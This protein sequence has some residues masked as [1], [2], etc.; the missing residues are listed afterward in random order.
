MPFN[1]SLIPWLFVGVVWIGLP[2]AALL[3]IRRFLRSYERRTAGPSELAE[4]RAKVEE[5]QGQVAD[6]TIEHARLR[7][8]ER[9]TNAL[10]RDTS[11]NLERD[12][13]G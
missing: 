5:L 11:R 8:A 9:F 7:E 1:S 4:L 12:R 3:L 13:S 6:L 2:I 10:L